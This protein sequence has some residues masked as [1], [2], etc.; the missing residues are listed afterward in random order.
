MERLQIVL[1]VGLVL[2]SA[3]I[4]IMAVPDICN[5][6]AKIGPCKARMA[7]WY[8]DTT[9]QSC[10]KFYYG[11]CDGNENRF[12]TESDCNANCQAEEPIHEYSANCPQIDLTTLCFEEDQTRCSEDSDCINPASTCCPTDCGGTECI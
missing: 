10:R 5:L 12:D 4:S 3:D 6:P 11:G 9:Y 2:L 1:L 7:R 8:F